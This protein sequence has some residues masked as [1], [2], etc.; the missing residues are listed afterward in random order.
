MSTAGIAP[1]IMAEGGTKNDHWTDMQNG[2]ALQRTRLT[3]METSEQQTLEIG[4]QPGGAKQDAQDGRKGKYGGKMIRQK[5]KRSSLQIKS[6][7][8]NGC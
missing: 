8:F 2:C 4:L 1:T 6:E 7:I 5:H 3:D